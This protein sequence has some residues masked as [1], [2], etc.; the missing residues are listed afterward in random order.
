[1]QT[2]IADEMLRSIRQI[3]RRISEHSRSLSR[4]VGLTVPQLVCIKA[5]AE[6]EEQEPGDITVATLSHRVELAPATVSRIVDRLVR[7]GLLTRARR[8]DDR[9][10]VCLAL[11]PAGT[12]RVQTLP[13]PLQEQFIQ[14]LMELPSEERV[15]LLSALRR[16][17]ELMDATNLD[18]API[19]APGAEVS[20][21]RPS[22]G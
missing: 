22:E 18:A 17:T 21:G 20:I 16:I 4:T 10:K 14:R 15:A 8:E 9:R 13:K 11:T 3:V 1:M 2:D 6:L 12:E 7:A 5:L 19:L